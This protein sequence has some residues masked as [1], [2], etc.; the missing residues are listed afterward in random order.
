MRHGGEV[1]GFNFVEAHTEMFL[2]VCRDYS[3]LPDPRGLR[4]S[5]IRFFYDALRAELK[6]HTRPRS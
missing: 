3:S 6:H 4:A 5:E 1:G 2:Q